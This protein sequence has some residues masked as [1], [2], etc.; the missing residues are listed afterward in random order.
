MR[1]QYFG[2]SSA[3][4]LT[5]CGFIGFLGCFGVVV[6]D[7]IATIVVDGYNPISQTISDLAINQK[8]WIQDVGLNLFAASFA[9]CGIGFLIIDMGDWKWKVGSILL[10]VLAADILVISEF[11]QYANADSFGSTVHFACVIILAITFTLMLI[12]TTDG[13]SKVSQNWRSFNLAT[14]FIWA[15]TAPFFFVVSDS[16]NGAYERFLSLIVIVWVTRASKLLFDK[17][18]TLIQA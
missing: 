15:A 18:D 6:T 8:A 13:L 10:F 12:L 9:A 5:I 14:A 17:K 2:L 4:I 11:D 7:I 3:T 16:W 1:N